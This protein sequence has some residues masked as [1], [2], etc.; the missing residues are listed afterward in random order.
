ME[1]HFFYRAVFFTQPG[2]PACEAMKPIWAQVAGEVS[3]EYPELRVGWGEYDVTE[4]NWEFL[5][6]L[7]PGTSGQGT[8]EIAIFDEECDLI[9]FN[10][11]GIMP[12]S[13]LKSFV[14]NSIKGG[15][16]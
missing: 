4:D 3:E 5:E 16:T 7:K 11:E 14:I 1:N 12:A 2:C 10:G 15:R 6:S 9:G 8:P 13:Q